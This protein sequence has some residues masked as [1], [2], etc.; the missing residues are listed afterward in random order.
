MFLHVEYINL[1]KNLRVLAPR[2]QIAPPRLKKPP[3]LLAEPLPIP[4][5]APHQ[6]AALCI[7]PRQIQPPPREA[8]MDF[9]GVNLQHQ[10]V[11]GSLFFLLTR[12]A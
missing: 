8:L 7:P 4:A 12:Q 6:R 5:P 11:T 3:L 10:N 1:C 2:W 9:C